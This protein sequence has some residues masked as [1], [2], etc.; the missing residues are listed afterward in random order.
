MWCLAGG[1]EL[2]DVTPLDR[3]HHANP[4]E[5]H[6]TAILRGLGHHVGRGLHLLHLVLGLPGPPSNQA[7]ASLSVRSFLPFG[8]TI[9]SPT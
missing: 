9:G 6:R 2:F 4:G 7:I 1:V 3:L 8:S 5:F